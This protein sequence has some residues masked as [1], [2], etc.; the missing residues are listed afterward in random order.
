MFIKLDIMRTRVIRR[1][2]IIRPSRKLGRKR[3]NPLDKWF[4]P[5]SLASCPDLI[6]CGI[7]VLG[8]L[9]IAESG[10][11]RAHHNVSRESVQGSNV[12]EFVAQV[13]NVLQFVK[14][15]VV[16]FGERVDLLDSVV[17]FEH[18]LADGEETLVGGD[19]ECVVE[20]FEWEGL[21]SFETGID[22]TDGLGLD[23]GVILEWG[24]EGD[25]L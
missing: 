3:I 4:N 5:I 9:F 14:E 11:F 8:N 24:R 13:D 20:V 19:A 6:F 22:L 1:I 12:A 15:P 18:G 23:G 10:F 7:D 17:F 25:L 21:E 2:Q 16:D